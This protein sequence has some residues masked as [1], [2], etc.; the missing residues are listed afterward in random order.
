VIELT[1]GYRFPAAHVLRRPDLS[2]AE[3][4]KLYGKCANPAGHGHNYGIEVTVGGPVDPRSGRVLD[5]DRLDEIVED[6]I[7]TRF[8]HRS[9]NADPLFAND[10]PTAEN[11]AI[12]I[13]RQLAQ[14]VAACGEARL[15][16]VRVVETR[17]NS[18]AYGVSE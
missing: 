9:L 6:R 3:N 14:P 10:V 16:R 1:R 15:R 7:L 5:P 12:A 18:F 13:H 17:K 11:L 4:Q 2:D 8:S